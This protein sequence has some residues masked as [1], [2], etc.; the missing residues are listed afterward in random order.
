MGK[1]MKE[2]LIDRVP[3]IAAGVFF[4]IPVVVVVSY[5]MGFVA[6]DY[7]QAYY[8]GLIPALIGG[9]ILLTQILLLHEGIHRTVYGSS[10]TI[11]K[12]RKW[13]PSLGFVSV[14]Y[15]LLF[16][17]PVIP[18]IRILNTLIFKVID[19]L[20]IAVIAGLSPYITIVTYDYFPLT[21]E[22]ES[23]IWRLILALIGIYIVTMV[24]VGGILL[25]DQISLSNIATRVVVTAIF[26]FSIALTVK[27][28]FSDQ[29]QN[30]SPRIR[31]N[32]SQPLNGYLRTIR[33]NESL[34]F[35]AALLVGIGLPILSGVST[36]VSIGL[37]PPPSG[38]AP[39]IFVVGYVGLVPLASI[40]AALWLLPKV[41]SY[42][43]KVAV[44]ISR[45]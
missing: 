44:S 31:R 43:L 24:I 32:D 19:S 12:L 39:G 36:A 40:A 9:G 35:F 5:L 41:T 27:R 34:T 17:L 10:D 38:V 11:R 33:D 8:L 28:S 45:L 7:M 15:L 25:S 14:M 6:Q 23:I 37:S 18:T 26:V 13:L 42:I 29:R 4:S 30:Q 20:F 16:F 2:E 1:L 3:P 21:Q 22:A